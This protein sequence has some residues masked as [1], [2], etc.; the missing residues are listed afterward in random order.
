MIDKKYIEY[1]FEAK[2]IHELGTKFEFKDGQLPQ[3]F[4]EGIC[5]EI[6]RLDDYDGEGKSFDAKENNK[7][8]EIKFNLTLDNGM[9]VNYDKDFEY[10]YCELLDFDNDT[11]EIYKF[12]GKDVK[13]FLNGKSKNTSLNVLKSNVK[14]KYYKYKFVRKLNF[15]EEKES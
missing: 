1:Y 10:L 14:H 12:N 4:T 8:V 11:I 5:K 3:R 15:I 13:N 2:K 7:N 9:Y 6:F